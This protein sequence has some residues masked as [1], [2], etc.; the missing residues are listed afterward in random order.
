MRG[1]RLLIVD[2][3]AEMRSWLR[4]G[5]ERLGAIVYEAAS[6]WE[7]LAR[8]SDDGPFDL[9]V[10]DMRMPMPS[11]LSVLASARSLGIMTPFI[12][13]TAFSDEA[14]RERVALFASATLVDKPFELDDLV[15]QALALLRASPCASDGRA[16]SPPA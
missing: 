4:L 16:G 2:D 14:L 5:L 7:C 3:D 1:R 9:V 12:L 13:I 8:L 10:T 6:G 11:G 15:T